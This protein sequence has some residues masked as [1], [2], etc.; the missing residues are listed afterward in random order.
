MAFIISLIEYFEASL[1]HQSIEHAC[2]VNGFSIFLNI[3]KISSYVLY[4]FSVQLSF[5][6]SNVYHSRFRID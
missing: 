1:L 4:I 2:N 3:Q 6:F 5:S